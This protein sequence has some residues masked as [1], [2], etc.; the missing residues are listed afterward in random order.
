MQLGNIIQYILILMG[1]LMQIVTVNFLARRKMVESFCL[2][3]GLIGLILMLAG[4]YLR[5]TEVGR[6]LSPMGLVLAVMIG[7]CVVYASYFMSI[8]IS[9]LLRR[10]QELAMQVSL[11]NQENQQILKKLEQL[12]DRFENEQQGNWKEE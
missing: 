12:E 3:W 9:E 4:V 5:P 10:N 2:A 8:K 1:V 7:F 6:Y 11:L